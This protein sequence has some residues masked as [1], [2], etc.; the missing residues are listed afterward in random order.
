MNARIFRDEVF[1]G[2]GAW[3]QLGHGHRIFR[4]RVGT[5]PHSRAGLVA[6]DRASGLRRR[7]EYKRDRGRSAAVRAA[8]HALRLIGVAAFAF[9]TKPGSHSPHSQGWLPWQGRRRGSRRRVWDVIREWEL[10]TEHLKS[11]C[12]CWIPKPGPICDY[13]AWARE[14]PV[15]AEDWEAPRTRGARTGAVR[16]HR[17]RRRLRGGRTRRVWTRSSSAAVARHAG[18]DGRVGRN[19]RSRCSVC[20]HSRRSSLRRSVSSRTSTRR[21]SSVSPAP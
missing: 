5:A 4:R 6:H 15:S 21:R 1:D 11:F 10:P 8:A 18:R 7:G 3:H 16:L 17:R 9:Q 19:C 13:L 2:Q 12:T 14:W 20:A